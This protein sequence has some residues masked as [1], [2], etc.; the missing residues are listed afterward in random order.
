FF[1]RLIG[2]MMQKLLRQTLLFVVTAALVTCRSF[3]KEES[4]ILQPVVDD[5][6][7]VA[8]LIVPGAYINGEAYQDL[9]EA[10]QAASPLRL[11]VALVRPFAFDLPNPVEVSP[12]IDHALQT[13]RDMGM[14]TE[15][16]F[17]AGHSL[18]GVVLQSWVSSHI[19][20]TSGMVMLGSELQTPMNETQVPVMIMS[21]D[22][23]GMARITEARQ[24]F[25]ELES[26]IPV[27][28]ERI[29]VNPVVVLED[30]NHMHVA[31]GEPTPTVAKYDIPSPMDFDT[32]HAL[33][34]DQMSA[35][36]SVISGLPEEGVEEAKSVLSQS[37]DN[38]HAMLKPLDDLAYMTEGDVDS[39]W[40]IEAQLIMAAVTDQYMDRVQV[41]DTLMT[42]EDLGHPKPHV[43]LMEDGNA[44]VT[45]FTHVYYP[46]P[47]ESTGIFPH[48]AKEM[49]SKLKSQEA[50]RE[51][52]EP[53]GVEFGPET[54]CK[55]INEA[56]VAL[57]YETASDIA[58]A[59][60]DSRGRPITIL[61]DDVKA[62]GSGWLGG[63][64]HYNDTNTAEGIFISS[65]SLPT[66]VDV[67]FG[68]G[69]MHYCKLLPP[70]R[71]LEYIMVDSLRHT[72]LATSK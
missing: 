51:V 22:L 52:L 60:F 63:N 17:I 5:G 26:L 10:V 9:G 62:T 33:M 55:D 48:T 13:M 69:G 53:L 44:N 49:A 18:G 70:V 32:A 21:G 24:Y 34:A 20:E 42:L 43:T 36:I 57:A 61:P 64:L 3:R 4:I 46:G 11:W 12:D 28:A 15:Y 66:G 8:L 27:N 37:H 38:T 40:T 45:T 16:I 35:F 23:D 54:S 72:E 6:P 47:L 19:D 39:M 30:V 59:R 2:V 25:N 65:P 7:D 71:A 58:K 56:A 14:D 41:L 68:I 29:Y 50:I 1:V 31:S 67:P